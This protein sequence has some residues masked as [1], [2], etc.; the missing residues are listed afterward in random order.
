MLPAR[1][2]DRGAFEAEDSTVRVPQ[3]VVASFAVMII[4]VWG[5]VAAAA[6]PLTAIAPV[7]SGLSAPVE[8]QRAYQDELPKSLIQAGFQL[9]PPNEVDMQLGERP[10]FIKCSTGGCLAEE[11]AFLRVGRLILPRLEPAPSGGFLVGLSVYDAAQKRVIGEAVERCAA[12]CTAAAMRTMLGEVAGRLHAD[13]QRPGTLD[14][15]CEPAARITIDGQAAGQTPYHGELPPGPHIV[16]LES[17]AERVQRDVYIAPGRGSRVDIKL[18]DALQPDTPRRSGSQL[19]VF[20]WVS[21]TAGLGGVAVGAAMLGI[22]GTGTC[23]LPPGQLACPRV[24]DTL[25]LGATLVAVGGALLVTSIV[26]IAVDKKP[27]STLSFILSPSRE[28]AAL[29]AV[30]SF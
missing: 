8:L 6:E 22:D 25:A 19:R 23:S 24:H 20:K 18:V 7:P 26:L 11:A 3:W 4:G 2:F 1:E 13:C 16:V 10:E 17:G 12:P 9:K 27:K 5:G 21:F 29:V 15:S 14:V 30:G 28:G